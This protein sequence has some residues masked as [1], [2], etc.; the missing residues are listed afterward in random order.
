[1]GCL[2][3]SEVSVRRDVS[4]VREYDFSREALV[5]EVRITTRWTR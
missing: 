2:I 4:K 5:P 1:M 3:E